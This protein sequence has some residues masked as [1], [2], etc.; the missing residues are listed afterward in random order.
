MADA[1][2]TRKIQTAD[3]SYEVVVL[4][5]TDG[6][7]YTSRKFNSIKAAQATGN[8]DVDAYLNVTYSGAVVTI[9]YDGQTDKLVTLQIWGH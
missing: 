5:A 2:I 8:E 1:T 4:T 6:E 3:P 7:T 9:N